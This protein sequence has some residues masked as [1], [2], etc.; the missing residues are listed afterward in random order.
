MNRILP[1]LVLLSG[2]A[3]HAPNPLPP[4]AAAQFP[5]VGG[6]PVPSLAPMLAGVTRGVVNIAVKGRVKEENPLLQDPF[7]RRFFNLPQRSQPEERET[8]ATGSGVIVDAGSGYVLTNGHVTENATRIEVTT[9]DNRRLTAKLIGTDSDTDVAVLQIPA[10]NLTAVPMGDSDR[11]Q[12]GDFVL[13]VGNPL[14]LAQTVSSGLLGALD[15]RRP[16]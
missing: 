6:A 1:A 7:F 8:Q 11:L 4:L 10:E 15:R 16:R 2:V 5:E 14:A 3:V 13:A 12:V 9:K